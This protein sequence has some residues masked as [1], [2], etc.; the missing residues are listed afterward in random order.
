[1]VV[2][3]HMF[4]C[5]YLSCVFHPMCILGILKLYLNSKEKHTLEG[6]LRRLSSSQAVHGI[7]KL[8]L[9]R[10]FG[11]CPFDHLFPRSPYMTQ[12]RPLPVKQ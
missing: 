4:Y 10:G 11:T 3:Y 12:T 5:E 7:G 1:M 9:P 6:K 2:V 8:P